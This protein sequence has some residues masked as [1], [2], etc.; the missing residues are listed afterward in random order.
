M[1][2]CQP[3]SPTNCLMSSHTQFLHAS[4]NPSPLCIYV[5]FRMYNPISFNC[6]HIQKHRHKTIFHRL[7]TAENCCNCPVVKDDNECAVQSFTSK[8]LL[9]MTMILLM[10]HMYPTE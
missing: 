3:P 10:H 4:G 1:A 5:L 2:S 9:I 6:L 7:L 8:L